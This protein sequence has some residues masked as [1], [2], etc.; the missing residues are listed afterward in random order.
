MRHFPA[1]AIFIC[2]GM[3]AALADGDPPRE[4]WERLQFEG[5]GDI[6]AVTIRE[7]VDKRG[8]KAEVTELFQGF[9]VPRSLHLRDLG[10][11]AEPGSRW[12]VQL[13]TRW[14]A[15]QEVAAKVKDT[16]EWRRRIAARVGTPWRRESLV[17]LGRIPEP[18]AA[19]AGP[20]LVDVVRV[21]YGSL[22][23][24]RVRFSVYGEDLIR[25]VV[26][27]PGLV[28][29]GV[30]YVNETGEGA[31]V[32]TVRSL[33]PVDAAKVSEVEADLKTNNQ[34]L[35]LEE[36]RR[37]Q[38]RIREVETAWRFHQAKFVARV[39]IGMVIEE[40]TNLGGMHFGYFLEE[41]LRGKFDPEHPGTAG[42]FLGGGHGYHGP[43]KKG[44]GYV[45]AGPAVGAHPVA[46][47]PLD[48]PRSKQVAEWLT[49]PMPSYACRPVDPEVFDPAQ[50]PVVPDRLPSVGAAVFN[51]SLRVESVPQ[52]EVWEGLRFRVVRRRTLEAKGQVW[53]WVHCKSGQSE[54]MFA[55]DELSDLTEGSEW[56]GQSVLADPSRRS[57][58]TPWFQGRLFLGGQLLPM[59]GVTERELGN[60]L[61]SLERR[62]FVQQRRSK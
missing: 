44:Q 54:W 36:V 56:W 16:E 13:T 45:A 11:E 55:G 48:D 39:R 5:P 41:W 12:I 42:V 29:L 1:L 35:H 60:C 51:P 31:G 25:P 59:A 23:A 8:V 47:I 14:S 43:E 62:D 32:I 53:S 57:P 6:A 52:R 22:E 3:G 28:V 9:A 2:A 27:G 18:P 10:P 20:Y 38:E 26:Q 15:P 49:M 37:G 33:I 19:K 21:L 40:P 7:T 58:E 17:L 4:R 24:K 61:Q 50:T 30:S 34:A 46:T